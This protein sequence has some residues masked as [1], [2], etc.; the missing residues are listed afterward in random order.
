M[1]QNAKI[2]AYRKLLGFTKN[3]KYTLLGQVVFRGQVIRQ[4]SSPFSFSYP[5]LQKLH[6]LLNAVID[7]T[8]ICF[9]HQLW[10][11][12]LLILRV[13]PSEAFKGRQRQKCKE[14]VSSVPICT[15]VKA[16]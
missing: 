15:E 1:P 7:V 14:C 11:L 4:F 2:V 3:L 8:G 10:G 12:R 9:Q 6:H 5:L 13:D 16:Y